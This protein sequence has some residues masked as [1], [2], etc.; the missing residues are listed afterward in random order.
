MAD[1]RW[2]AAFLF[3]AQATSA[4]LLPDMTNGT[5]DEFAL[6]RAGAEVNASWMIGVTN[7]GLYRITQSALTTA[8]LTN[9]VGSEIRMFCRTQEVAIYVS[10][11]NLMTAD[12]FVLFYGWGHDG[13]YSNTNVYWLGTGPGGLRMAR[14]SAPPIGG[15][16]DVT[17]HWHE[18]RKAEDKIYNEYIRP[19][20]DSF[21]HWYNSY[22][23]TTNLYPAT[24]LTIAT[25]RRIAGG[26]A[27]IVALLGGRSDDTNVPP[28]DHQT[29]I[30]VSGTLVT[31]FLYEADG[32]ITGSCFFTAGFL[33]S[34][35]T[36]VTLRQV[37]LP[38]VSI[39]IA[40]LD[41]LAVRY[42]RALVVLNDALS[43]SGAIGTNNYN[44]DGFSTNG[45]YWAADI[46]N[47][48]APILLTNFTTTSAAGG[49][50]MRFGDTTASSNRYF[51]CATSAVVSATISSRVMFRDLAS[52]NRQADY[53]LICPYEFR[54]SAYRLLAHRYRHGLRVAVAPIS[55]IY[56]EFSYGIKDSAAI[57]QFLGYAYHHWRTP[58]PQYVLLAGEGTSDP[59]NN[60]KLAGVVDWVPVHLGPSDFEW[61]ALE[62]WFT[63]VNSPDRMVD[64]ALGRIAVSSDG[65]LSNAVDRIIAYEALASTNAW[66]KKA[67]L[68]ADND[69]PSKGLD[70]TGASDS[71][72]AVHLVA[73]GFTILTKT[74][75]GGINGANPPMVHNTIMNSVNGGQFVVNYFGH[76]DWARW[77]DE[78]FFNTNDVPA[79]ANS[80]L[81]LFT[82]VTC[83]NGK[84][85][86]P[87]VECLAEALVEQSGRGAIASVAASS[88]SY[89]ELAKQ[90]ADGFYTALVNTQQYVRVGDVMKA[91][92]L[93]LWS[94]LPSSQELLFYNLLGDP[95]L[96][97]NPSQ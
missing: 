19:S 16:T 17:S 53:I 37:L 34:S 67:T 56:N 20:D 32:R 21:N 74:Y 93:Q 40:L 65:A 57:K 94:T 81:P 26:N 73:G 14:R 4:G 39:D 10:S 64:M 72:V 1:L 82:M 9:P 30:R 70:F 69:E 44:V 6:R 31:N 18:V 41:W 23:Y 61:T 83:Q 86:T 27:Q 76:G 60:L 92:M 36:T 66:R 45:T 11:P 5:P 42:T 2:L 35:S 15:A 58:H 54:R 91:G 80:V 7:A 77:A 46:S 62:G 28:P 97:I 25:D 50:R 38:G 84:F 33:D 8:G 48:W 55:D 79:L 95:A 90:F 13:D 96:V 85:Q 52:T 63:T 68:V 88:L 22:L 89:H 78:D 12:D 87:G 47:P 3:V 75:L 24:N 49:V 29:E 43:F 71:N 51:V 59:K